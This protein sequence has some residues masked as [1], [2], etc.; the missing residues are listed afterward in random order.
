MI[1]GIPKLG[2]SML[3]TK[4][5]TEQGLQFWNHFEKHYFADKSAEERAFFEENKYFLASL[6]TIY[7][8]TFLTHLRSELERWLK[9]ILL[10]EMMK[11]HR[12]A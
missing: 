1:Y 11:T 7:C 4:I 3:A 2:I 10:P 9:D 6:R 8:I 12:T 5:P